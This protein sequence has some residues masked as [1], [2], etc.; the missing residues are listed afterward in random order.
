MW[1]RVR[2]SVY[3][4]IGLV[5]LKITSQEQAYAFLDETKF[6]LPADSPGLIFRFLMMD[7]LDDLLRINVS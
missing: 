5:G 4:L 6:Y 3:R 1:S 2:G 7:M